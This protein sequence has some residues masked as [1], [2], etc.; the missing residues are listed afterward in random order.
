[1]T[2]ITIRKAILNDADGL[3]GLVREPGMFQHPV[4]QPPDATREQVSRHLSLCLADDS[5]SVYVAV[6]PSGEIAGYLSVHWLPYL[7]LTG[8]EGFVSE[9]F[10]R[11]AAR[12]Q[13][14]GG[15][16][17]QTA[18]AEA[19]QRGCSRLSLLNM[20]SRE[21]YRRGFYNQQGWQERPDAI[22]FLYRLPEETKP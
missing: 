20:R 18:G 22:N 7:M 12:S 15:R 19:R 6:E 10:V 3:T 11:R 5:H 13:G 2:E 9:L 14:V 16:L 4:E 17:L 8:P 1:M 21:S